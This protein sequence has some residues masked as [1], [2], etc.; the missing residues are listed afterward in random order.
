MLGFTLWTI[1]FLFSEQHILASIAFCFALLFKQM[2]LF[3]SLAVFFYLPYLALVWSLLIQSLSSLVIDDDR[4]L[5]LLA[6][7]GGSVVFTFILVL[8][9]LSMELGS[10]NQ[11]IIPL[12]YFWGLW[13]DKVANVWCTLNT[14]VKLRQL[15]EIST[16][17]KLSYI[18]ILLPYCI[19]S[20]QL[21]SRLCHL[22]YTYYG[23]RTSW[24]CYIH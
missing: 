8:Y 19:V 16:L 5:I 2:A 13:E 6:K 22:E 17:A 4:N 7:I 3:Y 10:I 18:Y 24:N 23:I 9:P 11:F 1:A 20:L 12:S 21:S 15:F 14:V